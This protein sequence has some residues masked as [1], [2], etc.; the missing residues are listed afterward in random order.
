MSG[1]PYEA[2]FRTH[3]EEVEDERESELPHIRGASKEDAVAYEQPVDACTAEE[4][5]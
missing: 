3:L 1:D 5:R 4:E 2:E